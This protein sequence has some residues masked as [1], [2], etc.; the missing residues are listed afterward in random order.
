MHGKSVQEVEEWRV[1]DVEEVSDC[2]AD[3]A[4]THGRPESRREPL[5]K[6]P[7]TTLPDRRRPAAGTTRRRQPDSNLHHA[8]YYAPGTTAKQP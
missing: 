1:W 8:R 2:G 5:S 6:S 3:P 4:R 7:V